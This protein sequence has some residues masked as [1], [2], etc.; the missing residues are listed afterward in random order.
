MG[1]FIDLIGHRKHSL[2][3]VAKAEKD[4]RLNRIMWSC[5]CDC[6]NTIKVCTGDWNAGRA[7]SCGCYRNR[8]GSDHPNWRHGLTKTNE[9]QYRV[10]L[11]RRYGINADQYDKMLAKQSGRCAICGADQDANRGHTLAVDHCHESGLIRGLLCHTCN[12]A[13]GMFQDDPA[14]LI[15]ASKYLKGASSVSTQ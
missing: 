9:Y 1:K 10:R 13:I 5:R 8:K 3:V 14:L 2:T 4:V 11:K 7:K 12:R 6:G 15:K